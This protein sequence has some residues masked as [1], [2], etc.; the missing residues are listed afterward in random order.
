MY[1]LIYKTISDIVFSVL[2]NLNSR[3]SKDLINVS[4]QFIFPQILNECGLATTSSPHTQNVP[5]KFSIVRVTSSIHADSWLN[6]QESF[7]F[8]K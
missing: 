2:G 6:E 1:S 8:N 7:V 5:F 4:K 3:Y